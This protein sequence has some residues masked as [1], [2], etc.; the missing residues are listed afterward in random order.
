MWQDSGGAVMDP[1]DSDYAIFSLHLLQG[2][3]R[4]ILDSIV[5]RYVIK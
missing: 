4:I 2:K 1:R 5:F 3:F